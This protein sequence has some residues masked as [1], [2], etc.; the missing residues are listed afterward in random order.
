MKK[1][2][3]ILKKEVVNIISLSKNEWLEMAEILFFGITINSIYGLLNNFSIKNVAITF[4]SL[5]GV[6]KAKKIRR[7]I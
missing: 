3:K 4:L 2:F 7:D 1:I 5:Y 6:L